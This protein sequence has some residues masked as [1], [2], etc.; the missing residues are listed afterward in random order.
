VNTID[1][2]LLLALVHQT[3]RPGKR[4]PKTHKPTPAHRAR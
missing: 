3:D 4:A 1:E 2:V